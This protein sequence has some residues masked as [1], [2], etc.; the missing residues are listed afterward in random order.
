MS[1]P[2]QLS[3]LPAYLREL[4]DRIELAGRRADTEGMRDALHNLAETGSALWLKLQQQQLA[5]NAGSMAANLAEGFV[6]N[7]MKKF[8]APSTGKGRKRK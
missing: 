2:T 1:A 3:T 4:A 6:N 8:G 7:M 5:R